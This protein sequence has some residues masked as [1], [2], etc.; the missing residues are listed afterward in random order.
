MSSAVSSETKNIC[1]EAANFDPVSVRLTSGR[2][3]LRTDSSMR[4]EKSLD[5]LLAQ[6]GMNRA[7]EML[8]FL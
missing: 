8:S 4:F 2:I 6:G 7:L 1:F 3:G 5:P